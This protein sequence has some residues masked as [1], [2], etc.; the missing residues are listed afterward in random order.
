MST[1]FNPVWLEMGAVVPVDCATTYALLD[2]IRRLTGEQCLHQKEWRDLNKE[3]CWDLLIAYCN[4]P[5]TL[6]VEVQ[7]AL[8]KKNT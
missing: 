7:K 4:N 2:E 3:Q 6:L 5:F 8:E 1:P